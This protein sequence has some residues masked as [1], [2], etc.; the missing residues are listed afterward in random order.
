MLKFDSNVLA[1]NLGELKDVARK[2]QVY[3]TPSML[4]KPTY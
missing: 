3:L 1:S 2:L 4:E